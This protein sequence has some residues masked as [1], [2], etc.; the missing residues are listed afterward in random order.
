MVLPLL[1]GCS[2]LENFATSQKP[3]VRVTGARLEALDLTSATL[4]F[5]LNIQNPS[6][7][8]LP[9]VNLDYRLASG[10]AAFLSGTSALQGVVPAESNKTVTLPARVVFTDLLQVAK[11]I[12]PGAVV[13]YTLQAGL[14][15]DSGIAGPLRLPATWSGK[16]PVPT[17]PEVELKEIRW[18]RLTLTEASGH[19]A[20]GLVNPNAFPFDL[21]SVD[22]RLQLGG[23]RVASATLA[24]EVALEASGGS[25]SVR[26]PVSFSPTRLGLAVFRMLTGSQVDYGFQGTL[27]VDTPFGPLN[28][29]VAKTGQTSLIGP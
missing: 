11:G 21:N 17:P 29:P 19:L 3:S 23:T 26:I 27:G 5:D 13:P 18:D 22:Y 12:R 9:L 7:V 24:Q 2:A 20:L 1:V 10:D 28:L 15:V 8:P 6:A 14:S 16:L 4:Q 25:G